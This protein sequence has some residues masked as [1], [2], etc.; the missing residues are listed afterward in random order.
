MFSSF[1][2]T[3][4][5]SDLQLANESTGLKHLTNQQTDTKQIVK[6]K[7]H[8]S[9]LDVKVSQDAHQRPQRP[10]RLCEV[11]IFENLRVFNICLQPYL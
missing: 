2:S 7:H 10:R 3:V 4:V 5:W 6:C 1:N 8:I 11:R 9:S